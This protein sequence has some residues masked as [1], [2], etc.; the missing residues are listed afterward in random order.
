MNSM[1]LSSNG[2]VEDPLAIE[3]ERAVINPWTSEERNIFLKKFAAFGKD[4][5]KIATFLD[6][7][8]TADCVEFYYKNHKSDSSVMADDIARN[9]RMRS[10][11]ALWRGYNMTARVKG[12]G[13][14]QDER[15]T[16]AADVLTS[17][18]G[19]V[20]SEATSSCITSSVNPVKGKRVRKCVK[21]KPLRKPSPPPT[22]PQSFRSG[23]NFTPSSLLEP[24]F[25][26]P[27]F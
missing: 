1:F 2:L 13:V 5:R 21:A 25:D 14:L 26:S 17:I 20:L 3:K 8:T 19:S 18:C 11:R 7:K 16:V 24:I 4:F 22:M 27:E 9:R 15:E 12:F 10:G 6:H 23:W